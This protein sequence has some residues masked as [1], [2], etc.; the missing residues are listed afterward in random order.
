MDTS[1]Q[2]PNVNELKDEIIKLRE[3]VT[4]L[5]R[6]RKDYDFENEVTKELYDKV[7]NICTYYIL[8]QDLNNLEIIGILKICSKGFEDAV[9]DFEDKVIEEEDDDDSDDWKKDK[10]ND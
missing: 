4:N 10:V 9:M 6:K 1:N 3:E 5:L 7:M 2:S 8:E